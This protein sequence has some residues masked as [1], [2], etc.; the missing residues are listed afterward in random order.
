MMENRNN[1][2]LACFLFENCAYIVNLH[3]FRTVC[4]VECH[5]FLWR[6]HNQYVMAE[7]NTLLAKTIEGETI[8]EFTV[9]VEISKYAGTS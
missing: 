1:P 7:G 9:Q 5:L 4:K 6:Y 3:V 2:E 8:I